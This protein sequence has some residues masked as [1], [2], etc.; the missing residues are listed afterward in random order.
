M[1]GKALED[2]PDNINGFRAI[3]QD[4]NEVGSIQYAQVSIIS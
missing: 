2:T 3:H 1:V 4:P